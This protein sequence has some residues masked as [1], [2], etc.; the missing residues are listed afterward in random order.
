MVGLIMK[1]NVKLEDILNL[2]NDISKKVKNKNKVYNFEKNKMQNINDIINILKSGNYNGGYYN[3][4]LIREPKLR[5]VM[6]LSLKDKIINYYFT[7][8]VL[9]KKLTKYLD[10]RNIAT[11]KNMGCNYGIKLLKK[12]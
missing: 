6:A 8:Y 12:I 5:V 4:F 9:E 10:N 3:I 11:R 1:E 7:K 2:Y